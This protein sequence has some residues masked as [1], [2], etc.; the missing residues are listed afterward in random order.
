MEEEKECPLCPLPN[1]MGVP[2]LPSQGNAPLQPHSNA[3]FNASSLHPAPEQSCRPGLQT[4]PNPAAPHLLFRPAPLLPASRATP[5]RSPHASLPIP[6]CSSLPSPRP[7]DGS[8]LQRLFLPL[9]V[10]AQ[11]SPRTAFRSCVNPALP[12]PNVTA[13]PSVPQAGQG[14]SASRPLRMQ[15]LLP[16]TFFLLP[17]Y[18]GLLIQVSVQMPP[19]QRSPPWPPH[20]EDHLSSSF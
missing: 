2:V 7:P 14:Y 13:L 11:W 15:F 8:L 10:K 17:F 18:D 9:Q 5:A 20:L 19:P 3:V 16:G 12:D 1:P 6:A 4:R